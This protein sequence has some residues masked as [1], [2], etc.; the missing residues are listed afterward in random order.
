MNNWE[1]TISH[2]KKNKDYRELIESCYYDDPISKAVNRYQT[3]QEWLEIKR[4]LKKYK[5]TS[6]S[7]ILDY[8]AGRG[9]CSITFAA[10]NFD[11][12]AIDSND[13]IEAGLNSTKDFLK[14]KNLQISAIKSDFKKIPFEDNFF[15]LVFARQSLH[16]SE[17]LSESCSEIYRVMKKGGKFFALKD[18]IIDKIED[19][20]I[21]LK[22]HPLHKF[23]K[24]ENAYLLKEYIKA[25][26]I[27]NLK[28]I[29]IFKTYASPINY[30]PN[31]EEK[32]LQH[33]TKDKIIL[34]NNFFQN[35][36]KKN[37]FINKILKKILISL[38]DLKNK[39]PGRIYSF[40]LEK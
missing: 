2:L 36:L 39:T 8:G 30:D 35:F 15:D 27:N 38:I 17:N 20:K 31:T 18:H 16:H 22:N 34:K 21:F 3:S 4:L 40:I 32:I 12:Y 6:G 5:I 13:G 33:Y 1:K 7:K 29:K 25:F 28:I 10:Y 9:V 24:D 37:D 14:K 19:K 11:T 23:T 26:K